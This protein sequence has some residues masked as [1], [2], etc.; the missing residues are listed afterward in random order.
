M[1]ARDLGMV[2][3]RVKDLLLGVE[4]LGSRICLFEVYSEYYI[5][6][7]TWN[8]PWLGIDLFS[9]VGVVVVILLPAYANQTTYDNAASGA[10]KLGKDS[11]DYVCSTNRDYID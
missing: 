2:D 5:H 4:V 7:G 1:Q 9:H 11:I 6:W 10:S 3:W 8:F